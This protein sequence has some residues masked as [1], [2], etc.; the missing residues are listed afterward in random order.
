MGASRP[1]RCSFHVAGMNAVIRA[2]WTGG[3]VET[4]GSGDALVL[5]DA[6][7]SILL[8]QTMGLVSRLEGNK[9]S[10]LFDNPA[11]FWA[12]GDDRHGRAAIGLPSSHLGHFRNVSAEYDYPYSSKVA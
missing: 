6:V 3:H 7:A 12:N 5:I 9:A 8:S 1:Y 10:F 2:H 4:I 11:R